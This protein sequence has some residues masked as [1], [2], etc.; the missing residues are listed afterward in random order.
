VRV[1]LSYSRT[2]RAL[3]DRFDDDLTQA[4]IE[5]WRD[6][7]AL[8]GGEEWRTQIVEAIEQSDVFLLFV[9]PGSMGSDNV[10][11]ELTVAEEDG[12]RVVPVLVAR[13]AIPDN[14]RYSLAGVQYTD[15]TGADHSAAVAAIL[16]SLREEPSPLSHTTTPAPR[17][18]SRRAAG[19]AIVVALLIAGPIVANFHGGGG[20]SGSTPPGF[21]AGSTAANKAATINVNK[22]FGFGA[23]AITLGR[24]TFSGHTLAI[25][26]VFENL[27]AT[28][29]QVDQSHIAVVSA[30]N[31]YGWSGDLVP[32]V[33]GNARARGTL[34]FNISGPF[35]LE[36]AVLVAGPGEQ[37][38]AVVPLVGTSDAHPLEPRVEHVTGQATAG[39]LTVKVVS[40]LVAAGSFEFDTQASKGKVVVHLVLEATTTERYG[41]NFI[42]NHLVLKIPN[43]EQA[44]AVSG[45]NEVLNAGATKSGMF[46]DFETPEPAVGQFVLVVRQLTN[47]AEI[48]ITLS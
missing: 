17:R 4:G 40:G 35:D 26:S 28:D 44:T 10:R 42:A 33:A 29:F 15:I 39:S 2:D 11:R 22:R 47:T 32:K 38:Q 24:A 36:Q 30:G 41:D 45:S 27:A 9:S 20:H 23:F 48:P 1:F 18:S 19:V 12:K 8:R 7:E 13:T 46:A 43:G 3:V 16:S 34:I 6:V 31:S 14:F 25:D 5:I 21:S 37:N